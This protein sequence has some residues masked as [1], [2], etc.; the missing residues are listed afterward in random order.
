MTHASA[1]NR[2]TR[3]SSCCPSG[4]SQPLGT[5]GAQDAAGKC[6]SLSQKFIYFFLNCIITADISAHVRF[7]YISV[8]ILQALNFG[9]QLSWQSSPKT[10]VPSYSS[11]SAPAESWR[12]EMLQCGVLFAAETKVLVPDPNRRVNIYCP[13]SALP[14]TCGSPSPRAQPCSS[15]TRRSRPQVPAAECG[16]DPWHAPGSAQRLLA[17]TKGPPGGLPI[18]LRASWL[19][20]LARLRRGPDKTQALIP[21]HVKVPGRG[22]QAA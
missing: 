3:D 15:R 9:P 1:P 4:H 2:G 11:S 16:M 7:Y 19:A 22:E 17:V 14:H 12:Q 20:V 6:F 10:S 8:V 5:Q 13:M 21:P 18:F